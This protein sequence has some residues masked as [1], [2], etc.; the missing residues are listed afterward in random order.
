MAQKAVQGIP[1]H[2]FRAVTSQQEILTDDS[3]SISRCWL[4][5]VAAMRTLLADDS[6]W[7]KIERDMVVI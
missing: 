3:V 6:Y 7:R 4:P 5:R 2:P 1:I